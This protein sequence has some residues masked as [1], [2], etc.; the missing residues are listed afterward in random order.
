MMY[1]WII[2][3]VLLIIGIWFYK[4]EKISNRSDSAN[5]ILDKRYSNGEIS[6]EEYMEQKNTLNQKN[7]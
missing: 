5:D 4:T 3:A 2:V 6:K 1:S 7:E